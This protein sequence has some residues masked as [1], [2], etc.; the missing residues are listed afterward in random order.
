[1]QID[2]SNA[3]V[4]KDE[5]G[6]PFIIV[7]DQAK[8]KRIHGIEAVKSHIIAARTVANI[9]RTSLGP[10]GLDK[11][12]LS[13]DGDITVTNDGATIL[14]QMEISNN[15]AKLLVQLSKSQD[16]E[17]GDGTTG[18]VVL[19]GALLEQAADLI[20][21]GIHPIRIADG[22]DKACEVAVAEL[23][24]ISDVIPFSR[25]KTQNLV[26]VARTSLGSKIVSKVQ[27]QFAQIAVDAVLSVADLKR[28]DVDFELI[29]VDSK[30]GGSLEDS[31][32]I[33]GVIVDKDFSHPQMPS[34]VRDAKLAILTCAFEPP[35]PKTKHKLDI[36]TV[37]EFKRLQTYEQTKFTEMIEQIKATGA[38]VVICQWGFDDEANHL[39]LQHKLPAVRWVGGP[40]I[41]LIAIATNGRI[42]PRFEDL[43]A[44]KLG[45]AGVVREM[46]FGTTREKMLVIEECANPRAVTVFVRGSNKMIIDEAKRSLHD[47]LCVVR[48]LVR[49][50][51]VVYGGGAAEIACS[52][53]VEDAATKSPGLEQYAM[54]AF[55][56]ALDS[57]PMALAE[58][59]G[60]SPIE[61]LA[62]V[63][64]RQ[65]REGNSRLGVDC[66]GTGSNGK[67]LTGRL[68]H[69]LSPPVQG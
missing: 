65:V 57:V 18:V 34:E 14:G 56:D 23:D 33:K 36:T 44:E 48:N 67:F 29:K 64:S 53:A 37:E 9:V 69:S 20:D 32:L 39:L 59:S 22:F 41:E 31:L 26:N 62:A 8:K 4:M 63:K 7:R 10:R 15:V 49:D 52:L 46:S 60:L 1:M 66:M 50:D 27:D 17:I 19:A 61:T 38:N 2:M 28:K 16:D 3:Q 47:A 5:S 30:P 21:K 13:P 45:R 68:C 25:E 54:R 58:N 55:A 40:E 24:R 12:L 6:R 11:I 51:R 43:S 42:V 35:K